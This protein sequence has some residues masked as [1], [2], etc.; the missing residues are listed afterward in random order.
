MVVSLS[1]IAWTPNHRGDV[2]QRRAMQHIAAIC[3]GAAACVLLIDAVR[4]LDELG[5]QRLCASNDVLLRSFRPSDPIE[6]LDEVL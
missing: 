5:E 2:E 3:C 1:V 4:L 6:I